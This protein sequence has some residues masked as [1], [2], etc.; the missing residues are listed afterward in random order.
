[1]K[2]SIITVAYNDRKGLEQTICSVVRQTYQDYEYIVIDGGSQDGSLDV[3]K[4][5]DAAITYWVSEKDKGVY[6][7]MNKAV[8][9]A[10]GEYCI[11]MNAGDCF[12]DNHVLQR[13]ADEGLEADLVVG[14]AEMVS[15]GK[16]LSQ[17]IPPAEVCLGFW[18]YHSVI[19]Q[20]AFMRTDMLREKHYDESLRIVSD[21]KYMLSEYL[22]R[23]YT[24]QVSSVV[25]CKFD[26]SGISSDNTKRLAERRQVL[27][28]LLP[29]MLFQEFERY[30]DF[31]PLFSN[32]LLMNSL[33]E[34]MRY[35]SLTLLISKTLPFVTK[36]YKRLKKS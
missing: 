27:I 12:H 24:Y 10:H 4:K 17:V 2:F 13:V 5:Y 32:I 33:K 19:H 21:W 28:E 30:K 1:M 29:P 36:I 14:I 18:L 25:V 26:T 31:K 20:A 23:T 8:D 34:V 11:F 16:V 15:N 9:V 22:S 3:L 35:R 7:A 6:N